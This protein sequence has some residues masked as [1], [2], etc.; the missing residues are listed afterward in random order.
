MTH[1]IRDTF[2]NIQTWIF[3]LDHTLYPP[4]VPLFAQM[5]VRMVDYMCRVLRLERDTANALRANYWRDY[6]T[7]LAGLMAEYQIDP[8]PFLWDVHQ[9]DFSVVPQNLNL[10]DLITR[11]DSRKI[12]YTN[13]TAPYAEDVIAA[14]GIGGVFDAIYGVEHANYLP[15]PN[16]AAFEAVFSL[17]GFDRAK[18]VMFE[19]DPRNLKVP[20]EMGL[21]TVLI[22]STPNHNNFIDYQAPDLEEFLSQIK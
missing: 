21:T 9:L 7:T 12:I 5:E 6:G 14:R 11:L 15:K 22:S 16:H 13:G 1:D 2:A 3:D 19:D 10:R 8:D 20:K 18:A 4:D 17:D